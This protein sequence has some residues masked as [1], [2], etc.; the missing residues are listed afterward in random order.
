MIILWHI[1]KSYPFLISSLSTHVLIF[2]T[3][4]RSIYM[5][6]KTCYYW[7]SNPYFL[8][9][10]GQRDAAASAARN[11]HQQKARIIRRPDAAI[12][13]GSSG[14]FRTIEHLS[15]T[16]LQYIFNYVFFFICVFVVR[17]P[18]MFVFVSFKFAPI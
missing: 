4:L 9:R 12:A 2:Y 11:L 3:H 15:V 16:V 18:S 7:V 13:S 14:A 17:F 5:L 10:I 1:R 8:L 6:Q